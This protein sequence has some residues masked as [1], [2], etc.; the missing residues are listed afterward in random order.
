MHQAEEMESR[1]Y[2]FKKI[3]TSGLP[4]LWVA[5]L[6]IVIDRYTKV[7]AM[8]NLSFAVPLKI[9]PIFNLTLVYN[10]GAAFSFLHTATGWQNIFLG[11]L[12]YIV[13]VIILFWLYK[14]PIREIWLNVALT[15]ILGGALGNAWD[16]SLYGYVTD[17]FDFHI[18]AWHFAIFNVADSAICVG[19]FMMIAHWLWFPKPKPR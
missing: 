6:L 11:S 18:G 15:L 9:L 12:A 17:F 19:A 3:F 5:I 1:M 4:W 2:L 13:S 10:S 8:N 16:R 7:W 14:L